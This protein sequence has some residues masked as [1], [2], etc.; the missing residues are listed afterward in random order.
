MNGP[1]R[2]DKEEQEI[3]LR[4]DLTQRV[5]LSQPRDRVDLFY[6]TAA[7]GPGVRRA[8]GVIEADPE[9]A[10]GRQEIR[11]AVC[12]QRAGLPDLDGRTSCF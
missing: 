3:S 7:S 8:V 4:E 6:R 12:Y 9:G 11:P 10:G 5:T 2:R 1:D